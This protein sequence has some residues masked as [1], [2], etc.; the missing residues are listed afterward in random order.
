[1]PDSRVR[2]YAADALGKF[3][4]QGR[5]VA[6]TLVKALDD[7]EIDVRRSVTTSLGRIGWAA[8]EEVFAGLVKAVKDKE[9]NVRVPAALNLLRAG[10]FPDLKVRTAAAN[11]LGALGLDETTLPAILKAMESK[12]EV[13]RAAVMK[14]MPSYGA[15]DENPPR[16]S[17]TKD[18][19]RDI[20]PLLKNSE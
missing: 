14:A 4:S 10:S 12:D 16:L 20:K 1:A 15:L 13:C 7:P 8:R 18:A 2:V 3:S 11:A 6:Q 17:L 19:I 9:R 5:Q